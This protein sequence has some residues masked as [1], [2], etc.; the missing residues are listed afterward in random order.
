MLL[1]H[2]AT[3]APHTQY[4]KCYPQHL[5]RASRHLETRPQCDGC[6]K[7]CL[8][9]DPDISGSLDVDIDLP[10]ELLELEQFDHLRRTRK[11]QFRTHACCNCQ[12]VGGVLPHESSHAYTC[13]STQKKVPSKQHTKT[14]ARQV[15]E[16]LLKVRAQT[17]QKN[18]DP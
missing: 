18:S 15:A 8:L 7:D 6:A 9:H 2:H 4:Q 11:G 16:R 1:V 13:T 10:T 12:K 14:D 17:C 5:Y 3:Q